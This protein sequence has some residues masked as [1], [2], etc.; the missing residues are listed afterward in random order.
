MRTWLVLL[1]LMAL[2]A[3]AQPAAT[4]EELAAQAC[5]SYEAARETLPEDRQDGMRLLR[6]AADESRQAAALDADFDSFAAT[7][8][9]RSESFAEIVALLSGADDAS[10]TGTPEFRE[11]MDVVQSADLVIPM[12]CTPLLQ[13]VRS[14]RQP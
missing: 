1:V 12:R 9:E 5:R 8:S 2:G 14:T 4:A 7:V 11:H 10:P 13:K 6:E 3:C